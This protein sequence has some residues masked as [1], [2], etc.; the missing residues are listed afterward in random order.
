VSASCR[1]LSSQYRRRCAPTRDHTG[2]HEPLPAGG[3][4]LRMGCPTLGTQR[5]PV[6]THGDLYGRL[7]KCRAT[8]G[9]GLGVRLMLQPRAPHHARLG[10]R[11]ME[12]PPL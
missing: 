1:A 10:H 9:Q 3:T 6:Q 4:P 2:A 11:D 7:P 5:L 12:E 8:D